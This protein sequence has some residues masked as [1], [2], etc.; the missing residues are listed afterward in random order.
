MIKK[1]IFFLILAAQFF[2][3]GQEITNK[4]I[5]EAE[6]LILSGMPVSARIIL[7]NIIKSDSISEVAYFYRG[8]TYLVTKNFKEA[9]NDY[10]KCLELNP[11]NKD[12]RTNL[13]VAYLAIE[14]GSRSL[15]EFNQVHEVDSNNENA[16][17]N[18][19]LSL[20]KVRE[21]NQALTEMNRLF[22]QKLEFPA[23]AYYI[24]GLCNLYSYNFSQAIIDLTVSK[25]LGFEHSS[26]VLNDIL[27]HDNFPYEI[28]ECLTRDCLNPDVI[29]YKIEMSK[30]ND[31][32]SIAGEWQMITS[33][34]T[35]SDSIK[36]QSSSTILR[37]EYPEEINVRY[38][39]NKDGTGF[40]SEK[41]GEKFSFNWNIENGH[42]L[43]IFNNDI[44]ILRQKIR[45]NYNFIEFLIENDEND[46]FFGYEVAKRIN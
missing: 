20:L 19:C 22:E 23:R 42:I 34:M 10:E 6:T 35:W 9:V 45:Y 11:K 37:A 7:N 32:I 46:H 17:I 1:L 12:C 13:G 16:I 39:F 40:E 33:L 25:K 29:K 31:T 44:V 24:K 14:D 38:T 2:V 5:K 3:Q 18:R 41:S 43:N 26:V 15:K 4:K 30:F 21:N 8:N 28:G 36:G 27:G